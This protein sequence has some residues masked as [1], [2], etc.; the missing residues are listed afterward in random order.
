MTQSGHFTI[1]RRAPTVPEYQRLRE[2]VGCDPVEDKA[3]EKGLGRSLFAVC[4]TQGGEVIGCGR[5]VG[6]DGLYFFIQDL[7]VDPELDNEGIEAC[8]MDEIMDFLKEAAPPG[9]FFCIQG[10]LYQR[11]ECKQYGF[12]LSDDE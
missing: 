11:E 12:R 3:V 10:C 7:M 4:A 6:D 1:T 2:A 8:L 5:V 9:A